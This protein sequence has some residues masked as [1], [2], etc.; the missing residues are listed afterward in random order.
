[1]DAME[2]ED[3]MPRVFRALADA[4]EDQLD[5]ILQILEGNLCPADYVEPYLTLKDVASR[6]GIHASTLAR[7]NVPGY[8]VNGRARY[9]LS[10]VNSY[11][12]EKGRRAS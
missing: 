5:I 12:R 8:C 3:I 1:M 6:L 2:R 4:T 11:I 7:W 10:E 9:L